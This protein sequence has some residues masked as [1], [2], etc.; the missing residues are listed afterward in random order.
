M[1]DP[2]INLIDEHWKEIAMIHDA[3]KKNQPIIE[4]DIA[5]TKLYSYPAEDYISNWSPRTK[6]LKKRQYKEAFKNN[7]F[8]LFVRD[9]KRRKLSSY[10]YIRILFSLKID[11]YLSFKAL[12]V[13]INFN[14]LATVQLKHKTAKI[15]IIRY[16]VLSMMNNAINTRSYWLRFLF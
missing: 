12:I 16:F 5:C 15:R 2:Y 6:N 4:F 7:Q 14:L 13:N 11:K 3:F 1:N 10:M 9:E 8:I